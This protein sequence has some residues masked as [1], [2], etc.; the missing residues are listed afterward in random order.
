VT[1]GGVVCQHQPQVHHGVGRHALAT[2]MHTNTIDASASFGPGGGSE[3]EGYPLPCSRLGSSCCA[4]AFPRL[5]SRSA[6]S[7]GVQPHTHY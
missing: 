1:K 7:L 4:P 3:L 6:L 5:P 2:H